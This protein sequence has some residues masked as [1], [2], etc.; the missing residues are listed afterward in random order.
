MG[1]KTTTGRRRSGGTATRRRPRRYGWSASWVRS[2]GPSRARSPGSPASPATRPPRQPALP[3]AR[4]A[5]VVSDR[6]YVD[7]LVARQVDEVIGEAG[8]RNAAH[9]K[10]ARQL[11]HRG[12][13][14]RPGA[15]ML[16]CTIDRSKELQAEPSAPFV[17]PEGG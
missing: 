12:A 5:M 10:I 2:W 6:E 4:S 17:I 13:A 3:V 9:L 11:R 1:R 14:A 7:H 8:N 16:N 15:R